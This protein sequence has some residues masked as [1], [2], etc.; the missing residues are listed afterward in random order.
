MRFSVTHYLYK[1][2][3]QTAGET[4]SL[5]LPTPRPPG[6]KFSTNWDEVDCRRCLK[7]K[8][9]ESGNFRRKSNKVSLNFDFSFN[10]SAKRERIERFDACCLKLGYTRTEIVRALM[11][12]FITTHNGGEND[13]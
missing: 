6:P 4:Y 1:H 8:G 7:R 12:E 3:D 13:A 11:E 2:P 9:Y 5:C 10:I